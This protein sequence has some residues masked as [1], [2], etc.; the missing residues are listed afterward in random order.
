[1]RLHLTDY[2]R[3]AARLAL[4]NGD[5]AKA[6]EHCENAEALVWETGHHRRDPDLE[7]LRTALAAQTT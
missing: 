2:H 6:R 1:M 5:R 4:R 7:K 3:A